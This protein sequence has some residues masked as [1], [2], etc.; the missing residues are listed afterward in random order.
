MVYRHHL[1]NSHLLEKSVDYPRSRV[2]PGA[3]DSTPIVDGGPPES[4]WTSMFLNAN[5]FLTGVDIPNLLTG[6]QVYGP[7]S[8]NPTE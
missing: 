2:E 1:D 4:V 6:L 7:V 3:R 5:A 8:Q